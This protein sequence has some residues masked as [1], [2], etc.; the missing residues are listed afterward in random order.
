MTWT[1]AWCPSRERSGSGCLATNM[2]V[3]RALICSRTSF[4]TAKILPPIGPDLLNLNLAVLS[5]SCSESALVS[6]LPSAEGVQRH[7]LG[8]MKTHSP[9][10]G[11]I[12]RTCVALLNSNII[13][14][15]SLNKSCRPAQYSIPALSRAYVMLCLGGPYY[16][17]QFQ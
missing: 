2:A 12:C 1:I 11:C 14:F 8:L 10:K 5:A 17:P 6:E 9:E 16:I 13:A 3:L 7:L 4:A 15:L